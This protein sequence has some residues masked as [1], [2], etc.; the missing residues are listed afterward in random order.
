MILLGVSCCVH[1]EGAFTHTYAV[2]P[3][4]NVIFLPLESNMYL[5]SRSYQLIQIMD[6]RLCFCFGNADYLRDKP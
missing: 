1:M 3:E 2:V 4:G 5:L 6:D